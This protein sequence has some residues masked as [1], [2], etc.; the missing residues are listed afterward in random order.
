MSD[1]RKTKENLHPRLDTGRNIVA[2]NEEKAEVLNA[3]F[4]SAFNSKTSGSLG[5]SPLSWKTGTE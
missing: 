3:F 4:A 2:N 1:K 5:K